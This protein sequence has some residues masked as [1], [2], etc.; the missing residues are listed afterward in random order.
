MRIDTIEL[1]HVAL[2]LKKP[3]ATP[4][5]PATTLQTVLVRMQS[6]QTAGWGEAS[7]GTGPWA[8]PEWAGGVFACLRDWLAPRLVGT[9]VDSGAQLH[10][11]LAA[12]QGNRY[13]KAALDTAWWDLS[14]R[15]QAVALPRLLDSARQAV[16][17][18][19]SFDRM[20]STEEFL[21]AIG[22]ALE[23]GFARVELKFRPGWDIP[24]VAAVRQTYPVQ[25]FHI[26]VEGTMG[27]NHMEMLCRL[28]DF[29]LA[30]IEQPLAPDDLV[31][32]AMVQD[33]IRTPIC[34]DEA[35]TTPHQAEMALDLHSGKY[36]NL[37]VGR[38]GG[39]T[40]AIQIHDACQEQG[41]PC[42][43]G[44]TP[45]SG[46][47]VRHGLALAG[48]ANCT[49]PADFFPSEQVLQTDLVAPLVPTR[50]P[51][52]GSLQIPLW[53]EPGI[54]IDPAPEVLKALCLA[55]ARL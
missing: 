4:A 18:G 22:Q 1:F 26:D 28:D 3:L 29:S 40:P 54:G 35:I 49:Y 2:P 55:V 17:L 52:D 24:M 14:A 15:L 21:A 5:G 16:Q 46:V 42:W 51:K 50:D 36:V 37:K 27:L 38:V 25:T 33:T 13:A 41:I 20:E 12:V 9:H 45:Q 53:S 39:L 7:P 10:E 34:L 23:A 44:T 8:G 30:M 19:A 32:S 47:G 43:V 6:G 11:R 48:K 31:G